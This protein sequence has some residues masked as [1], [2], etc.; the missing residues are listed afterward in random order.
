MYIEKANKTKFTD[1]YIRFLARYDA[2]IQMFRKFKAA[3]PSQN[4]KKCGIKD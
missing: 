3:L 2:P 1:P 4:F